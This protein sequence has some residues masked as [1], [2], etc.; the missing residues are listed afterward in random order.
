MKIS[1]GP[2]TIVAHRGGAGLFPENTMI[3]FRKS[4]ELG[5]DAIECDIHATKDGN[6]VV[7]HDPDLKGTAGIDEFISDLSLD[8]IRKIRLPSGEGIP[9][10]ESVL[11]EIDM[12][13]YVELKSPETVEPLVRLFDANPQFRKK[14]III[15]FLHA[16]LKLLKQ[17]YPD[18]VVGALL[19]DSPDDSVSYAKSS[20]FT[21]L[22][23]YFRNI[24]K[25]TVD[26]CHRGGILVNVWTANT[27]EE[28]SGAISIGVDSITTDRPDLVMKALGRQPNFGVQ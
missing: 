9:E 22:G 12:N 23:F 18:L 17:K 27:E 3:A 25:D 13:F 11:R 26:Q 10:L 6:L 28:I 4:K 7:I 8:E 24:T 15:S 21:L 2:I 20:G 14:C 16:S 5:A 1:R 19:P